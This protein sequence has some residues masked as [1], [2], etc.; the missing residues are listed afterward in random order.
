MARGDPN[1]VTEALSQQAFN[2]KK[3]SKKRVFYYTI[4]AILLFVF[5]AIAGVIVQH[6]FKIIFL[7]K[8]GTY[9]S[10][11]FIQ[12]DSIGYFFPIQVINTGEK[13]LH[14]VSL[15]TK[16][17]Y[18]E[19][20]HLEKYDEIYPGNFEEFQLRDRTTVQEFQKKW[21]Y[22]DINFSFSNCDVDIF[23]L[24][25]THLYIPPQNCSI[26]ICDICSFQANVDANEFFESKNFSESVFSPR[27]IDLKITPEDT[28]IRNISNLNSFPE[29]GV[30][31]FSGREMC[32]LEGNCSI[33][34]MNEGSILFDLPKLPVELQLH[35]K[36]YNVINFSIDYVNMG[37]II[38]E[39]FKRKRINISIRCYA[40]S[41]DQCPK[42]IPFSSLKF[43]ED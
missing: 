15:L 6:N 26:Y 42:E 18:M 21:C 36:E 27:R 38:S 34:E 20:Y 2:T 16:T 19:D 4:A 1:T 17:C 14:N 40:N 22:P 24:N 11:D 25:T 43:V 8:P 37:A 33:A 10:F 29:V 35:P 3:P 31:F 7:D 13:V 28:K 32:V 12:K 39:E 5:G 9:V 30:N 41:P 23:V